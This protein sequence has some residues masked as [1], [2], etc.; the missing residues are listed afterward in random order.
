M[1]GLI[2]L[3]VVGSSLFAVAQQINKNIVI[4]K[5]SI[6][7][8]WVDESK[9]H[10]SRY[11]KVARLTLD[12]MPCIMP[13]TISTPIPNA[14]EELAIPPDIPNLWKKPYSPLS[15]SSNLCYKD[16]MKL[17]KVPAPIH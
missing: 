13:Y 11:G 4:K 1:K 16:S 8:Q 7:D 3:L 12:N 17:K 5:R 2:I 14:G 9:T 15:N 6:P 10:T